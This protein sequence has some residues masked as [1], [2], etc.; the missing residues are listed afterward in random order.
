MTPLESSR[1]SLFESFLCIL[2][3]SPEFVAIM[4]REL[5]VLL[6]APASF[7]P[8]CR[9]SGTVAAFPHISTTTSSC[10]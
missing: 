6:T 9:D 2:H 4:S 7:L 8:R 1:L 10:S 5:C 3:R